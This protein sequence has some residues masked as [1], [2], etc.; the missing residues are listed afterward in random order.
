MDTPGWNDECRRRVARARGNLGSCADL[1]NGDN[2]VAHAAGMGCEPRVVQL[3]VRAHLLVG[4]R[5]PAAGLHT[6]PRHRRSSFS[7]L[8]SIAVMSAS[9]IALKRTSAGMWRRAPILKGPVGKNARLASPFPAPGLAPP[10]N[11][12]YEPCRRR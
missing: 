4:L 7:V 11:R 12:C 3:Q 10:N 2:G 5:V 1:N 9:I 6:S 8:N